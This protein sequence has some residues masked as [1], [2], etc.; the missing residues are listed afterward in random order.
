M[1]IV[2]SID[3]DDDT[4]KF[5]QESFR[6]FYNHTI[7]PEL[8]RMEVERIQLIRLLLFSCFLLTVLFLFGLF[9]G[10]WV[11]ALALMIP[12]GIYLS[13]LFY[14]VRKFKQ[15]FKPFVV[16][17]ILDYL[18]TKPNYHDL[19]FNSK[20]FIDKSEFMASRIFASPAQYYVGEDYFSGKIG[21]IDFEMS[22]LNVREMSKVRNRLQY[23]FRGV[24]MHATFSKELKGEVILLPK[25][26]RQYLTKT[27]KS[28]D[29]R[30]GEN[31]EEVALDQE[32][33]N[34]FMAFATP[35]ADLSNLLSVDMQQA[36]SR[37]REETEKE[38]YVSFIHKHIYV[39]VTESRDLLEP[40]LWSSNV[41]FELI[42]EFYEDIQLLMK[43]VE[44]FNKN[45]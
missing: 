22:E 6:I 2:Q 20:Q 21:G 42:N 25:K 38:I 7:Y 8:M 31:V 18:E 32:F 45:H 11:I 30:G 13:Y 9:V 35:D 34:Y 5:G 27:I 37:Y 14:R 3:P 39:G 16:R 26:F 33:E 40:A 1:E 24:F 44:D 28:F 19:F 17:L 36:L 12:S 4:L 41:N 23:V 43:V 10:V 15:R 29:L